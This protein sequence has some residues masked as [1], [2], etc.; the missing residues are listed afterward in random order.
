[1]RTR[2]ITCLA[3][4]TVV[5]VLSAAMVARADEP[6]ITLTPD[7]I[8]TG[9]TPTVTI[10]IEASFPDQ[11]E[12]N[13]VRV[14]GQ[15]VKL[16]SPAVV[17]GKLSVLLPKLDI[18]GK[19]KV[20]VIGKDDKVVATGQ[21]T[22]V[23]A[24]E[25]A[26]A[27]VIGTSGWLIFLY[28]ILIAALPVVC[29]IYDVRKSYN[30]RWKVLERLQPNASD[31]RIGALL[32]DMDQG[33]TGF[34]GLTRGIIAL[35]LILV[36]GFAVFHLVV[37]TPGSKPPDIA[38]KL[39]MLIAGTLTAITGFYFGSKASAEATQQA[40]SGAAKAGAAGALTITGVAQGTGAD[41]SKLTVTGTGYRAAQGKGTVTI[42][43]QPGGAPNWGDTQVVVTIPA[44]TPAGDAAIVVTNDS[45]SAS[46]PF[47]FKITAP[48]ATPNTGQTGGAGAPTIT[49]VSQ[50]TGADSSKLT[51]TGTGFG[52]AQGKG[53]VTIAGQPGG[54]PNW[55][56]TQIV[57]TIPAST[58]AGD[59]AIVV[60]ND[61]GSASAPYTFKITAPTATPNT[62]QTVGAGA[63]TITGA[64]WDKPNQK[65]TVTGTGFG[66]RGAKSNVKV[67][68][69]DAPFGPWTDTQI[70]ATPAADVEDGNN[71]VVTNDS[72]VASAEYT[73]KAA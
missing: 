21:L 49:A 55:G 31:E 22:Y 36:L 42:A 41:S 63:P 69:V 19:A 2:R 53:T 43:G 26:S 59:A 54:A 14:G 5:A 32:K 70:E 25:P 52:A 18:V 56:D 8:P 10:P 57:V 35:M 40:Q 6:Q 50:G 47:S 44:S 73:F 4:I 66:A 37:I 58:P 30:E 46:A 7:R 12:I 68:G 71:I 61:S 64:T 20:E 62:G 16:N 23:A 51:V 60:T 27:P 3:A 33:P 34:T 48:T 17:D 13:S 1:M 65:L 15:T 28:V 67:Q 38:E 11:S 24:A 39:L 29:T 9:T 72:G 45:G